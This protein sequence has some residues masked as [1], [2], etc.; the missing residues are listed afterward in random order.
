M[1]HVISVP[2][3]GYATDVQ[4]KNGT[5]G[6]LMLDSFYC[7]YEIKLP[8]QKFSRSKVLP[9]EWMRSY[10]IIIIIMLLD[11]KKNGNVSILLDF[12]KWQAIMNLT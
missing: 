4:R 9:Y 6:F 5:L 3:L 11:L 2:H 1:G 12:I 7:Y 8:L 10:N